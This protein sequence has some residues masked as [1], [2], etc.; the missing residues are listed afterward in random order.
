RHLYR[1]GGVAVP[2][3]VG[4][5]RNRDQRPLRTI[6]GSRGGP[7]RHDLLARAIPERGRHAPNADCV[8]GDERG[9]LQR[10][11]VGQGE[12]AMGAP[13]LPASR[14]WHFPPAS[15]VDRTPPGTVFRGWPA[16]PWPGL[17]VRSA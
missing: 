6:P 7:G 13:C 1:I 4:I 10:L 3:V 12:G 2:D 11:A 9:V 14:T 15:L 5:L 8:A 16:W 17:C